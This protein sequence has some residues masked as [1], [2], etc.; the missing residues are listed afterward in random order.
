M[1]RRPREADGADDVRID[2]VP[3]AATIKHLPVD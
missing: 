1:S 2:H 3:D